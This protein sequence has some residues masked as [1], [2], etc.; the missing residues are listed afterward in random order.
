MAEKTRL[1]TGTTLLLARASVEREAR[2]AARALWLE[3][4]I[5]AFWPVWALGAL[6]GGLV[7]LGVPALLPPAGHAAL[8]AGFGAAALFF[9]VRGAMGL[10]RP[11]ERAALARLDEGVPGRPAQSYSDRLAAGAGDGGAEAL[12]AAHQRALAARAAALRARAP[13]LRV[14]GRDR[15]ALRHGGLIALAA[16]AIAFFAAEEGS[17]V[18]LAD[19]LSPGALTPSAPAP[20]P[21]LEAWASPPAYTGVGAVYLT[22]LEPGASV[23][24]PAGSE[25]TLRAFDTSAPPALAEGVSGAAAAFANQGAG[26]YDAAFVVKADGE[27]RVTVGE[28]TLGAWTVTAIPDMPPEISFDGPPA[29]GERGALVLAYRASDDYGLTEARANIALDEAEAA[30]LLGIESAGSAFP[31][32]S[33]ELPLPAGSAAQEVAESLVEDLTEHPWAGLPVLYRLEGEDAAGQMAEA[34]LAATLPARRFYHP[35][36]KALIEQRR[37]LAFSAAAAPRALDVLEAV[38]IFPEEIIDDE[39][40]F[41][42]ARMAVRRLGYA[43]E[44][45]RLAEETES[46]V[47]LLWRAALRLEDGDL[48]NA[49]ERLAR[50]QERLKD[51]IENGAS[52]EELARLMQE[53]REAMRD[54]M[55]AMAEEMLRDQANGQQPQQAPQDGQTL[56]QNDL[57]RMLQELEEAIRNGQHELARQMLQALAEMMQNLQMAQPGQGQ[58]GEGQQMMDQMGDMIGEQQGLADRSFGQSQPGEGQPGE[59]QGEGEGAHRNQGQGEGEGQEGNRQ[60][61]RPGQGQGRGGQPGD[62]LG[63]IARDQ[64]ALQQLLDDLRGNVPGSVGE[65]ARRALEEADRAMGDAVENLERGDARGAVD[66]QVRALDALREGRREM[67]QDLAEAEGRGEGDQAGRD[68]R[69]MDNEREDPLGRPRASDGPM[70][71]ESVEVPSATLGKRARELQEEIRRRSGERERPAEELDYLERLLDRF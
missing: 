15:Y 59:G 40:G 60:G 47:D 10:H 43:L 45:G 48:A 33:L 7:L 34:T 62:S 54:Y 14:S 57:E 31:P 50:A 3:R 8:L 39:T 30:A 55:Q 66:D 51:A 58:P 20:A 36:A 13:D 68:G 49:A 61:Q 27:V 44:D 23:A 32:I 6:F 24:L 67:G 25:I 38:M 4:G 11:T 69:G 52:D 17:A 42:L 22:R 56:S 53:L 26:V 19:Q 1:S 12:W 64:Q 65:G 18:R 28:G 29:E 37:A 21:T 16:G 5:A 63:D 46:I 9:L 41:L 2:K 70:D 71:G 35:V